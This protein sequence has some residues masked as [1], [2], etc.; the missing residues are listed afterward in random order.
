MRSSEIFIS[1]LVKKTFPQGRPFVR[2][3][4][5]GEL[6]VGKILGRGEY[7]YETYPPEVQL[8]RLSD[9]R[10][11]VD[12]CQLSLHFAVKAAVVFTG[13]GL[14][15]GIK[16]KSVRKLVFSVGA[17]SAV[18][19][20]ARIIEEICD[21]TSESLSSRLGLVQEEISAIRQEQSPRKP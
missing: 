17:G 16:D 3:A 2:R 14:A 4:E 6:T 13:L 12:N 21:Q 19:M 20:G 18:A 11:V 15:K 9:R 7:R 5:K 1:E 10:E 8:L